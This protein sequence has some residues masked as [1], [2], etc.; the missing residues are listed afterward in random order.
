MS[1]EV[2]GLHELEADLIHA[3]AEALPAVTA[4]VKHSS[5]ELRD[6][7]RDTAR[8]TAGRHGKLY[9][10]SITYET[11]MS[12]GSILGEVGPD[13]SKPQGGMGR[14]FEYGSV[15]QPPHLDG[16]KATDAIE[17]KFLS[18]IE[19]AAKGLL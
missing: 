11:R 1:L 14:G 4:V 10:R 16:T 2:T 12:A 7:W 13:S 15:H 3:A 18:E 17:P 8:V 6:T 9:P 5:E 19:L